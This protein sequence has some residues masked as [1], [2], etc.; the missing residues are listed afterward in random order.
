MEYISGVLNEFD[1]KNIGGLIGI[2]II[3]ISAAAGYIQ[4]FYA[5]RIEVVL[6]NRNEEAKRFS[7]TYTIFFIMFGLMNYL[8]TISVSYLRV[9]GAFLIVT[10]LSGII[11]SIIK[12]KGKARE[13]CRRYEEGKDFII[14]YTFTPIFVC[15]IST[16]FNI[17]PLSCAILG[18]LV[19]VLILAITTLNGKDVISTI[20]L[21]IDNEKWYVL[22]RMND[23]YLICGN[24]KNINEAT[25]IRLLEINYIVENN[26]CF[27]KNIKTDD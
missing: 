7:F 15:I 8:S 17:K 26:L 18:A 19:E 1:I 14:I 27:E 25:K 3:I 2:C 21:N 5:S 4:L 6:M 20:T 10:L 12:K 23:D 9:S 22:K 16:Q 11:L 24:E 13:I